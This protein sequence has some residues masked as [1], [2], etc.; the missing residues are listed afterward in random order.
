MSGLKPSCPGLQVGIWVAWPWPQP[1]LNFLCGTVTVVVSPALPG[2]AELTGTRPKAGNA[3]A[4]S[5]TPV[6][7]GCFPFFFFF[8]LFS[9]VPWREFF[10]SDSEQ[11]KISDFYDKIL[12]VWASLQL[13]M[14][15]LLIQHTVLAE[16][17]VCEPLV[18]IQTP[19]A[20]T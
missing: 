19:K 2:A 20:W 8:F 11:K 6:L 12:D 10:M 16:M 15:F 13:K 9:N 3:P 18:M 5:L 1:G 14:S 4:K 7:Q 17:G